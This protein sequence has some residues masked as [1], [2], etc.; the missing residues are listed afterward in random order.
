MRSVGCVVVGGGPAGLAAARTAARHGVRVLLVDENAELGGQ[1]YR[2]MPDSFHAPGDA[3]PG[4]VD[5]LLD[6]GYSIDGRSFCPLGDAS[7]WF[8][9]SVIKHFR[10]EFQEH[11]SEKGC[12]FK[13]TVQE[14]VA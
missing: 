9:R 11:I 14:A 12:P 8:P 5:L 2:Q 10:D 13:K 7:T 4:D 3:K 1:Y 6:I